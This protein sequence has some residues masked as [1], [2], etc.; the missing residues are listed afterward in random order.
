MREFG[1][2]L[3]SIR[4]HFVTAESTRDA[5][6]QMARMGYTSGQT[7]GTY[8]Y[9]EP[10][11]FAKYAKEAGIELF[12]THYEYGLIKN[13]FEE[14]VKYHQTIGA[15]YIGIGGIDHSLF[16]S[17]DALNGFIE[18]FNA[19]AARYA[20]YG[21]KLT[22]HNHYLEFTRLEGKNVYDY[23]IEGFDKKNVSFCLDTCWAQYA[24]VDVC[25]LIERLP[26]R[27]DIIHL[28]DLEAAVPFELKD[29]TILRAPRCVEVG[30]GNL[31]FK[32][33]VEAG[34][35]AGTKYF[36]V[37]DE[38]YSTGESMDSIKM[39]A[40]YIKANLIEK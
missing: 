20:E 5:F 6:L 23:M 9:I 40:D 39:S 26:G 31:D 33:I 14:T 38:Y 24:G 18:E 15:K 34:E 22:Y 3:Y 37:E 19:L 13:H 16:K 7:A 29:G 4:D 30:S 28:K 32:R 25:G 36:I 27:V 8:S 12:G 17:V 21:F 11:L 35:K 2:Q 1:L 10:E